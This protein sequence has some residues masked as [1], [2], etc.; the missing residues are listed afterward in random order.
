MDN[1]E[2]QVTEKE[3]IE[4]P[5]VK[6]KT[7]TQDEVNRLIGREK[8]E[9]A[10]RAK[11][12]AEEQYMRELEQ[13]R[14]TQQQNVEQ[15]DRQ[16]DADAMYQQVQE[17]FNQEMERKRLE[18]EMTGVANNFLTKM[19]QGRERFED[20]DKVT[21]KLNPQKFPQLVYLVAGLDNTAE[22][23]YE[24]V[25]N[26]SK[27]VTINSL[28]KEDPKFAQAELQSLSASIKSNQQA[29]SEAEGQQANAPLDRLQPSRVAG[30]NGKMTIGDL[31]SQ[32]W[33][34]G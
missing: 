8:Q 16:V 10:Q 5:E 20:F 12:E 17:K 31:R 28:A 34:R 27:F 30:S 32:P 26:P 25:K 13:T 1:N 7:F 21:E 2:L 6:E 29:Q 18:E 23:M 11:R 14:A 3:V 19:A 24:L 9:A 15:G 22:V 4:T 33:L